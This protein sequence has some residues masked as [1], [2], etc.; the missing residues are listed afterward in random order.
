M[1]VAFIFVVLSYLFD[2]LFVSL[3][4]A[5][6]VHVKVAE[7]RNLRSDVWCSHLIFSLLLN[8]EPHKLI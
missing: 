5:L 8:D 6:C 1:I 3:Y 4:F 7:I 2:S